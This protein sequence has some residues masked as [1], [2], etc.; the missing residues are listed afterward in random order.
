MYITDFVCTYQLHKEAETE[1]IYRVQL[2]QALGI[3]IWDDIKVESVM[4]E[5]YNKLK[6]NT[7]FHNI[8]HIAKT[9]KS[10]E[11]IITILN[12]NDFDVFKML[13]RYD[14]FDITHKCI[15]DY[16]NKNIILPENE[17]ILIQ[18]L[19]KNL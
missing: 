13:F 18:R 5:L 6:E 16:L 17:R 14:L 10:L 12:C 9:S 2:L 3:D 11:T 8:I 15:C 19:N 4:N 1:H 7:N